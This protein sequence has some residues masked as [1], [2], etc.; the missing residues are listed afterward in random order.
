[1]RLVVAPAPGGVATDVPRRLRF[2]A[3]GDGDALT[4]CFDADDVAR[5]VLPND[6]DLG[7]TLIHEVMGRFTLRGHVRGERID[8]AGRAVFEFLG[9]EP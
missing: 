3:G 6:H 9:R 8:F 1:M 4:G 5:I 7:T 2:D